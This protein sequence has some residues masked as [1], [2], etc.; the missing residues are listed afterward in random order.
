VNST[1]T[2]YVL[3]RGAEF[4]IVYMDRES[5]QRWNDAGWELR[6]HDTNEKAQIAMAEWASSVKSIPFLVERQA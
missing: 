6:A 3:R 5:S 2:Y 4:K 1:N